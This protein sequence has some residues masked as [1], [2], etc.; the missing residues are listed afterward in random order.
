MVFSGTVAFGHSL[1]VIAVVVG[2]MHCPFSA[3][4]VSIVSA[5]SPPRPATQE[6]TDGVV[7]CWWG[8]G[9]KAEWCAKQ[10]K[11][12]GWTCCSGWETRRGHRRSF[13]VNASTVVS[14][15]RKAVGYLYDVYGTGHGRRGSRGPS[16]LVF[17][18]AKA[19]PRETTEG[20]SCRE[21]RGISCTRLCGRTAQAAT[22][23]LRCLEAA[24]GESFS[25]WCMAVVR[26]HK[27]GA[28]AQPSS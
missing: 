27:L 7:L 12:S 14:A 3:L 4:V 5:S 24:A 2:V 15:A 13:F 23:L 25:L 28:T 22:H 10:P 6:R 8:V 21:A 17:I 16:W 20:G 18:G 9:L 11:G 1:C 26:A 19:A